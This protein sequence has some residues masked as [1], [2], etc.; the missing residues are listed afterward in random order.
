MHFTG[1]KLALRT[2]R[3]WSQLYRIAD[4]L[5]GLLF[6]NGSSRKEIAMSNAMQNLLEELDE[7]PIH[8]G[9]ADL[10]GVVSKNPVSILDVVKNIQFDADDY[11]RDPIDYADQSHDYQALVLSWKPG[12]TSPPHNHKGSCCAVRVLHG[13]AEEWTYEVDDN[14][15]FEKVP[16]VYGVGSVFGGYDGDTH[17]LGPYSHSQEGLV[18]LHIYRP[19][20][21]LMET[22]AESEG[23]LVRQPLLV[24]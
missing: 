13:I 20:L 23:R 9:I 21:T 1:R 14:G 16:G 15:D 22:F 6:F 24:S 17:T 3:S 7:L 11:H 19:A 12:Q 4:Q 18:T 10:I 8:S 5:Q 2:R